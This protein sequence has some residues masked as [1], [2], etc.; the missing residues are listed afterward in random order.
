MESVAAL[1][2]CFPQLAMSIRTSLPLEQAS[3][4]KDCNPYLKNFSVKKEKMFF[5]PLFRAFLY[6][7]STKSV[8]NKQKKTQSYQ[9]FFFQPQNKSGGCLQYCVLQK[10]P[11][12]QGPTL[13]LCSCLFITN[14][15]HNFCSPVVVISKKMCPFDILLY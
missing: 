5:L 12:A 4:I 7:L 11:G 6:F 13:T 15:G 2:Q 3:A 14:H 1:L 8:L 10:G 9:S